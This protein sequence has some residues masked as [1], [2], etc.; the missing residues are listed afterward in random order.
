MAG[1]YIPIL[2]LWAA[3]TVLAAPAAAGPVSPDT[4][5]SVV[6]VLPEWPKGRDVPADVKRA[7]RERPEGTGVAVFEGGYLATNVHVLR[8][9]T[10][11]RVRLADGRILPAEIVGLDAP[12]DIALIKASVDLPV[13]EAGPEPALADPVCAIGNQFGL[14]LSVTCGVVSATHRSGVG[15]N[16][17]EDFIQTDAVVNPGASGG[18][19]VDGQGRLVGLVSAI[20]TKEV[21]ANVG[22]NFAASLP[23]V[24]RVVEDLK[25]TGRVIRSRLGLRV[26]DLPEAARKTGAGAG[27]VRVQ[28]KGAAE[29]A[30]LRPGDVI[31]EIAGR[32]ILKASGVTSA[33]HLFR[34]GDAFDL[35]FRR[36]GE[37]KRVTVTLRK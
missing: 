31:V 14:G 12:T 10:S 11:V 16:P 34:R 35:T 21:D 8:G 19:L 33:V 6:S 27:V 24:M 5:R 9:S 30:G 15:F 26:E 13:L 29:A 37:T 2:W 17:I 28:A 18:A 1:R 36:S 20:F 7:R 22:V 32:K 4:L 25:A 3:L 23:L